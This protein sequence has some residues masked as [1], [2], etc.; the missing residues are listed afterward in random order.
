MFHRHGDD[1]ART[2]SRYAFH[3]D[4]A[5]DGVHELSYKCQS[6]SCSEVFAV[7]IHLEERFEKPSCALFVHPRP[8]VAH[9][10]HG[11][12]FLYF[13]CHFYT[14]MLGSEFESVG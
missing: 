6:Y 3:T 13:S 4:V 9:T 11:L 14:P 8:R 10:H 12:A 2:F 1:K 7:V 5:V